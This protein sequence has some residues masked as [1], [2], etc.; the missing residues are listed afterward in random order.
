MT[1]TKDLFS[2]QSRNYARFRP[3]YP[4]E[5][6][7]YLRSL[8]CAHNRAWDAACGNGQA[9][10]MLLPFFDQVIAT[11]LSAQQI[12]HALMREKINYYVATFEDSKIDTDTVDLITVAQAFHWFDQNAFVDEVRR[13]AKADAILAIWCYGLAMID[14]TV[15]A[16]IRHLYHDILGPFWEP[17]RKLVETNYS[18]VQLPFAV[19]DAPS[20]AMASEWMLDDLYGYLR[21]WSSYKKFVAHTKSD[22]LCVLGESLR[23]GFGEHKKREVRWSIAPKIWRVERCIISPQL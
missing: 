5:L 15:D 7:V 14:S 22:P 8:C 9:A 23:E 17:E 11:D 18:D 21:T 13:V 12:A 2:D 3:H 10:H 16:I 1:R 6:F 19:I 4:R 20:F